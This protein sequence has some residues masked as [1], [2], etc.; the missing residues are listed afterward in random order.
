LP[1]ELSRQRKKSGEGKSLAY[2]ESGDESV[3]VGRKKDCF[4]GIIRVKKIE[5]PWGKNEGFLCPGKFK[6]GKVPRCGGS[7]SSTP[8]KLIIEYGSE[9]V[10]VR[11]IAKEIGVSGAIYRHFRASGKPGFPH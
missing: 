9:N 6:N 7:K 5:Y 2:H 11:R 3:L 8:Q 4:L 10:T 1:Q